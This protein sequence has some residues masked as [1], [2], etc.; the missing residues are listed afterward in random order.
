LSGN[1]PEP[2]YCLQA[3]LSDDKS[4]GKDFAFQV[5]PAVHAAGAHLDRKFAG[6]DWWCAAGM[7]HVWAIP[8]TWMEIDR[9]RGRWFEHLPLTQLSARSCPREIRGTSSCGSPPSPRDTS[10]PGYSRSRVCSR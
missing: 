8:C 3:K 7:P 9:C 5:A 2:F 10:S 4:G 6:V 1:N